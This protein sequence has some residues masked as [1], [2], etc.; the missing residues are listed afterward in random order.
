MQIIIQNKPENVCKYVA[1]MI[2]E[3]IKKKPNAVL[4]F[5]AGATFLGIYRELV[6]LHHEDGLDFS[7][8]TVFGLD[9]YVGL[10]ADH[11]CSYNTIMHTSFYDNVN[12]H[13]KNIHMPNGMAA[14]LYK[15]SA[16][17]E[18]AIKAAGGIDL[19]LLGVGPEGHI[20]YNEPTSS[21]VSRTRVKSL[22]EKTRYENSRYFP[23][24]NTPQQ[25]ITMGVGTI[26]DSKKV[27][28][29]AFGQKKADAIAKVAEGPVT[30]MVPG[31]ALQFHQHVKVVV[32]EDAASLL[33]LKDYHRWVFE[34]KELMKKR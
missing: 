11:P 7:K 26:L 15:E 9:E 3:T 31:S 17:Y 19:C 4:S 24:G 29:A 2:A 30:A 14:D 27:I 34:Q 12:F 8:V 23:D 1:K 22:M 18:E 25:V 32:D 6:H 5:P 13:P 20:G 16:D 21:L 10:P 33:K 28:L